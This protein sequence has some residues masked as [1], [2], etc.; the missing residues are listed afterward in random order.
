VKRHKQKPFSYIGETHED[1]LRRSTL[2]SDRKFWSGERPISVVQGI[3]L[4]LMFFALIA[5]L[6][7]GNWPKGEAPWWEK[8]VSG[9]GAFIAVFGCLVLFLVLGNRRVRPKAPPRE[10]D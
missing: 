6:G 10:K 3:G 2:E 5:V 4:A 1:L 7:V 8:I 9:Y